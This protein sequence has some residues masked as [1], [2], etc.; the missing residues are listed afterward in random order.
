MDSTVAQA[1]SSLTKAYGIVSDLAAMGAENDLCTTKFADGADFPTHIADLQTKWSEATEKEAEVSDST[2]WPIVMMLLPES[3]NTVVVSMYSTKTSVDLISGLLVHWKQLKM[4]KPL[5]PSVTVLQ[6]NT[7]SPRSK[8]EALAKLTASQANKQQTPTA[9][10][11][12][13]TPALD[14]PKAIGPQ[15]LE[16]DVII[17]ALS[18]PAMA[19]AIG[20]A[21]IP[22]F[23]DLGVSN[24]CFVR[25]DTFTEYMPYETPRKGLAAAKGATFHI[26][27]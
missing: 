13:T 17:E 4:Q 14:T 8:K 23:A 15:N 26:V 6:A 10:L 27:G 24:H 20:H 22:T 11:A 3:W 7:K 25:R 12:N 19:L 5:T 16:Q 21:S 9:N 1:W 2:T 18:D